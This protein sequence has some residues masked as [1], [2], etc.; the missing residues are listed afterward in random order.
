MKHLIILLLISMISVCLYSEEVLQAQYINNFDQP[1]YDYDFVIG[2]Q[3]GNLY[4]YKTDISTDSIIVSQ[5]TCNAQGIY[6]EKNIINSY[7]YPSESDT[8][9][10]LILSEYKFNKI[11]SHVLRDSSLVILVANEDGTT[12]NH[13]INTHG[14]QFLNT[15]TTSFKQYNLFN[16]Y[17]IY[18]VQYNRIFKISLLM[19]SFE[20][21]YEYPTYGYFYQ[22]PFSN[23]FIIF[24][25][26]RNHYGLYVNSTGEI[27]SLPEYFNDWLFLI[28]DKVGEN[29]YP[30]LMSQGIPG[31]EKYEILYIDNNSLESILIDDWE[32]N[33]VEHDENVI[34]L[35]G[36]RYICLYLVSSIFDSGYIYKSFA[37]YEIINNERVYY[38][39]F[40]NLG[41]ISD[42]ISLH[43]IND[44]AIIALSGSYNTPFNICVIDL[45]RE[46]LNNQTSNIENSMHES[47]NIIAAGNYFYMQKADE[48][49]SFKLETVVSTHDHDVPALENIS[50]YPNP[51]KDQIKIKLTSKKGISKTTVSIYDIKGRKVKTLINQQPVSEKTEIVWDGLNDKGHKQASGIYFVKV[52]SETSKQ[53]KKIMLL[54]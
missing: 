1:A 52:E 48:F 22:F 33:A 6:S 45:E 19:D 44:Q 37:T 38:P 20:V 32:G 35:D 4:F 26:H 23:D 47:Y 36:D 9:G 15:I 28:I 10:T 49:H 7:V 3:D 51:F 25:D 42:P 53:T 43:R 30:A 17:D 13:E 40:P 50:C 39:G 34:S 41:E 8:L 31:F 54:K 2:K 18:T 12:E 24:S 27:S 5:F 21:L 46:Q 14:Y 11:Y 16:E 29:Y